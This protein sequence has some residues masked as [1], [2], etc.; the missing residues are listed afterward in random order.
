[1]NFIL[2]KYDY[3][4]DLS[5]Q[6]AKLENA[7]FPNPDI[8]K[9]FDVILCNDGVQGL[10]PVHQS[11][12]I[13]FKNLD[14]VPD[15]KATLL[16]LEPTLTQAQI[17]GLFTLAQANSPIQFGMLVSGFQKRNLEWAVSQGLINSTDLE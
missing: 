16:N 13:Y 12:L 15:L 10:M 14:V 9:K 4:L 7:T 3:L 11:E 2:N 1:M 6:I 17:D 5:V 8:T